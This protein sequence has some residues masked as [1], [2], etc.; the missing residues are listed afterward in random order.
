M[1]RT[2][3]AV[4]YARDATQHRHVQ[5]YAEAHGY[6]LTHVVHDHRDTATISQIAQHA[7]EAR[8]EVVIL[9]GDALLSAARSRLEKELAQVSA[10]CI[11]L[12]APSS[13][14]RGVFERVIS[15]RELDAATR[16]KQV[17]PF[18]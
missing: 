12:G 10:S 16:S 2:A 1:P 15:R 17:Q 5:G 7:A 9:P 3:V 14:A 6:T 11:V 18:P 4:G 13:P 8:A